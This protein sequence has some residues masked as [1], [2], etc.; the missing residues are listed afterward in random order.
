LSAVGGTLNA[1]DNLR[2]GRY[3]SAAWD[4]VGV[5]GDWAGF[6]RACFAG[7]VE[8][9]TRDRGVVRWDEVHEGD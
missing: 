9:L 5:A 2:A 7:D 1:V 6:L 3:G 4:A 8:V